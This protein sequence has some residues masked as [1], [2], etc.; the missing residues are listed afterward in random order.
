VVA[1][2]R[3]VAELEVGQCQGIARFPV[4]WAPVHDRGE[5]LSGGAEIVGPRGRQPTVEELRRIAG[6]VPELA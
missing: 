4:V 2:C 5:Q 6:Q 1:R 3:A